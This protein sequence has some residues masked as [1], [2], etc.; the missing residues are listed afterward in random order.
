MLLYPA[1]VKR[2][3]RPLAALERA[4]ERFRPF[5]GSITYVL[6]AV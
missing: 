1:F 4:L 2:V 5:G 3:G 6:E